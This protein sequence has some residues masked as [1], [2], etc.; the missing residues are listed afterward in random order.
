ML[1][2]KLSLTGE[3]S[4]LPFF[5]DANGHVTPKALGWYT[6]E[7]SL[8]QKFNDD[9][10]L[11]FAGQVSAIADNFGPYGFSPIYGGSMSALWNKNARFKTQ[12]AAPIG[13]DVVNIAFPKLD[14]EL[15]HSTYGKFY[16]GML[17]NE[18]YGLPAYTSSYASHS[19][20]L[21]ARTAV[22]GDFDNGNAAF[23]YNS[24]YAPTIGGLFNLSSALVLGLQASVDGGFSPILPA[25]IYTGSLAY[26][27]SFDDKSPLKSFVVG[28]YGGTKTPAQRIVDEETIDNVNF[29][30]AQLTLNWKSGAA[31]GLGGGVT[32]TGLTA[33]GERLSTGQNALTL[34]GSLP[35]NEHALL[36]GGASLLNFNETSSVSQEDTWEN[37]V[38]LG[39][40][41]LPSKDWPLAINASY[42]KGFYDHNNLTGQGFP[43]APAER[44]AN[45]YRYADFEGLCFS[46]NFYLTGEK[47]LVA[48]AENVQEA[49]KK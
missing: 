2:G 20:G 14:L 18:M 37:F 4:A 19:T 22:N 29:G 49:P 39:V 16:L 43:V 46:V 27:Y 36:Y 44:D 48:D 24:S 23:L 7:G 33:L 12:F 41:F 21:T 26:T 25:T 6:L 34:S 3:N 11:S 47:V 15:V 40:S 45:A 5:S 9:W 42:V 1:T 30:G 13:N 10:S 31:V 28:A 32:R 35:L 17:P 8:T 38:E